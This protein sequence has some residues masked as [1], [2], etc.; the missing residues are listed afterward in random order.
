MSERIVGELGDNLE[1]KL[2][3]EVWCLETVGRENELLAATSRGFR[4]GLS[5]QETTK[6]RAPKGR[7]DPDL[8]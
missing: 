2:P 5:N 6:A 8:P 1:A 3:I 7:C 4:L